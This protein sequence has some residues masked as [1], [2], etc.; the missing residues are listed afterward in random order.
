M[1]LHINISLGINMFNEEEFQRANDL[2]S[3]GEYVDAL[4]IYIPIYNS[5]ENKQ[6]IIKYILGSLSHLDLNLALKYCDDL[7]DAERKVM[8]ILGGI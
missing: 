1:K 3:K 6:D 4:D 5:I 2:F 8:N 7:I